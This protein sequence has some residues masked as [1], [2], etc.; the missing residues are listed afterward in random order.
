MTE[1]L[2]RSEAEAWP[3]LS[4]LVLRGWLC[5]SAD[6]YTQRANSCLPLESPETDL[7]RRI[8]AVEA[9]YTGKGQPTVFKLPD[10]PAWAPLDQALASRGYTVATPSRV[11]TKEVRPTTVSPGFRSAESFDDLWWQGFQSAVALSEAHR[12]VAQALAFQVSRPVVARVTDQGYDA[13]WA[14][15]SLVGDRA[16]VFDVVVDPA[17]RRRGLGR[18]LMAGLEA[19]AF[20]RGIRRLHLQVLAAN[21]P[22]NALYEGLGFT[23]AYRYWYRRQKKKETHENHY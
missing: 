19:E 23:E 20:R 12:P 8:E 2:E 3:A 5:R 11:M 22:A 16:W 14:F 21:T 13:A 7:E 18:S 1:V 6:G 9:Y 17:R 15:A 4:S 10:E